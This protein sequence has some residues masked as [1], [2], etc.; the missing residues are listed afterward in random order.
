MFGRKKP[1]VASTRSIPTL[2]PDFF[3]EVQASIRAYGGTDS[4]SDVAWGVGNAIYNTGQ[5]YFERLDD[6]RAS[7]DFAM[8]FEDRQPSDTGAAD[9][10]IDHLVAYDSGTQEFLGTLLGRLKTVMS[11]PQ[12]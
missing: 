2:E 4:Y 3:S 6:R 5:N 1:P 7:R 9:R 8:L 12:S 11:Q 10:M